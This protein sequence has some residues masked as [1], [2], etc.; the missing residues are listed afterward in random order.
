MAKVDQSIPN[1]SLWQPGAPHFS[2]TA[3]HSSR[4]LRCL[5]C[6][7]L[8]WSLT[9]PCFCQPQRWARPP[10]AMPPVKLQIL[11]AT[12]YVKLAA[13]SSSLLLSAIMLNG[14][15]EPGDSQNRLI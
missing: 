1:Q 9:A 13:S 2:C 4:S 3:A 12:L 5:Q 10:S 15:A 7:F 8:Q 14:G 11:Q 6:S